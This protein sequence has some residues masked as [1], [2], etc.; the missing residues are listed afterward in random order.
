MVDRQQTTAYRSDLKA[1]FSLGSIKVNVIRT[2]FIL[3][4]NRLWTVDC[5]LLTRFD[6][7]FL[8]SAY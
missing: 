1:L 5:R 6:D 3:N 7:L 4:C 2:N 8:F